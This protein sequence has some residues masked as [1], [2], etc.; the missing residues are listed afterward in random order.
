VEHN[1]RF[2]DD[3]LTLT[4]CIPIE[5]AYGMKYKCTRQK[6]GHLIYLGMEMDWED[7]KRGKAFTTGMHF[8]D[9]SYPIQIRSYPANGSMVTDSQRIGVATGNSLE[10]K[11]FAQCCDGSNR[12]CRMWRWLH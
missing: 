2:I 5:E 11:G 4:G 12:L 6:T 7:T 10:H 9:A 3:I 1:Y 8:R